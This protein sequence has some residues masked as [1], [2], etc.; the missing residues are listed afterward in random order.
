MSDWHA[1]LRNNSQYAV[2]LGW[3][4]DA[5]LDHPKESVRSLQAQ[6]ARVDKFF[7]KPPTS[8]CFLHSLL[9]LLQQQTSSTYH[10]K[11][12]LVTTNLTFEASH[13]SN[14]PGEQWPQNV[15]DEW[16][17]MPRTLQRIRLNRMTRART[18]LHTRLQRLQGQMR[19]PLLNL[20]S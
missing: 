7:P 5:L 11:H 9:C 4:M 8:L 20:S 14:S 2:S 12:P 16:T 15:M 19:S 1:S 3:H 13:S 6:T 10:W 17:R 18:R